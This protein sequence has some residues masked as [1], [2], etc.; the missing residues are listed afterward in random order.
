MFHKILGAVWTATLEDNKPMH[1]N[2]LEH[3]TTEKRYYD[4]VEWVGGGLWT[5]HDDGNEIDLDEMGEGIVQRVR[6]I[7]FKKR[8]AIPIE[9][10]EDAVYDEAT[11]VVADMA[12]TWVQTQDVYAVGIIDDAADTG[13]TWG[14]GVTFAN[15][16]HPI[17]GGATVSNILSP[18]VAPSNMA[19]QLMIVAAEK[20]R[21]SNGEIAPLRITKACGPSNVRHRLK[22]ILKS[23]KKDDTANNAIN[24]L[25]GDLSSDP[26]SIPYMAST[27]NWFAKTNAKRGMMWIERKKATFAK[28][29]EIRNF[30][31]IHAGRARAVVTVSNFRAAIWSLN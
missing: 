15:S 5:E 24:A 13:V 14:D 10:E 7:S 17:K 20:M 26:V 2:Y 11:D 30:S 25:K 22:E 6:P 9:I 31:R 3:S 8:M 12:T 18:A 4:D 19:I 28:T 27:T 23:E 21:G 1:S 16:A 29:M